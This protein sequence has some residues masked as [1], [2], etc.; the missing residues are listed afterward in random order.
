MEAGYG[1][2][3]IIL[4]LSMTSINGVKLC[5]VNLETVAIWGS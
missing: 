3:S 4:F 5:I 2:E 1:F